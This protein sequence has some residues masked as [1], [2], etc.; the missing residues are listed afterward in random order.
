MQ[1]RANADV[2]V[3]ING[4]PSAVREGQ[5]FDDKDEVVRAYPWLFE[6]PVEEATANPGQRRATRR[7]ED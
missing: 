6:A 1:V 4:M 7:R 3:R 5:A 2:V